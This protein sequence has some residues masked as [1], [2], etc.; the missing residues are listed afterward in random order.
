MKTPSST[1]RDI[2]DVRKVRRLVE[3]M[4]EHDLSEIDLQQGEMRIQLRRSA[5]VAHPLAAPPVVASAKPEPAAEQST[6]PEAD[7][8]T[9]IK[10]PMVGT[11]YTAADPESPPFVKVGDHVGPD[12]TVCVV[13]AMKVFNQIPAEVSGRITAVLVENG[14]SVEFGQPLFK[15]ETGE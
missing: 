10:S 13:E 9:L 14:A 3:L 15:V 2:F 6:P 12:T 11:F 8:G 1:H 7:N 4:K 5:A